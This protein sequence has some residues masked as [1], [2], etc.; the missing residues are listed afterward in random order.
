MIQFCV[1]FNWR[2]H[3][4]QRPLEALQAYL[5]RRRDASSRHENR[6]TTLVDI[7]GPF[8]FVYS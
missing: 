6:G 7:C 3:N 5:E 8:Y 4:N 1:G 2:V